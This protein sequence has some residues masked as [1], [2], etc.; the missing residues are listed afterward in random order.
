M[1]DACNPVKLVC[2][3]R[4]KVSC[5]CFGLCDNLVWRRGCDCE[6]TPA[7]RQYFFLPVRVRAWL[8]HFS[9]EHC[10]C[11]LPLGWPYIL[12]VHC[13]CHLFLLVNWSF[14]RCV[15]SWH[16]ALLAC[17]VWVV[18]ITKLILRL[19]YAYTCSR[20]H[21]RASTTKSQGTCCLSSFPLLHKHRLAHPYCC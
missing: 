19:Y 3:L 18:G 15:A 11:H 5:F 1:P 14:V 2:A 8:L 20:L 16:C 21:G 9:T 4:A 17:H 12:A 10:E 7:W 6:C 13:C